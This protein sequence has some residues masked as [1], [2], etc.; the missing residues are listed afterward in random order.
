VASRDW[1]AGNREQFIGG[2]IGAVMKAITDHQAERE[3]KST[4]A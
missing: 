1:A 2:A 4:T 3:A